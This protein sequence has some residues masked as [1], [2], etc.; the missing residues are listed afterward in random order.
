MVFR[1]VS[2]QS[3]RW[4]SNHVRSFS[5][6]SELHNIK[7]I[8]TESKRV[9]Y[10]MPNMFWWLIILFL[11]IVCLDM[12][13]WTCGF[14]SKNGGIGQDIFCSC[15]ATAAIA[16]RAQNNNEYKCL[17]FITKSHVYYIHYTPSN[18]IYH[19]NPVPMI[20]WFDTRDVD[21]WDLFPLTTIFTLFL[22]R[23]QVCRMG[24]RRLLWVKTRMKQ[25]SID[26]LAVLL[27]LEYCSIVSNSSA[28]AQDYPRHQRRVSNDEM[29]SIVHMRKQSCQCFLLWSCL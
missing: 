11:D 24:G 22:V 21:N 19:S 7:W 13:F 20:D 9:G 4:E 29:H 12:W 25:V 1:T 10:N 23:E 15:P 17:K 26:C 2:W 8:H 27:P 18:T 28:S 6:L 3:P 14:G 5:C 16:D